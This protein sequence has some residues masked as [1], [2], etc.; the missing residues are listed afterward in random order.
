MCWHSIISIHWK[1]IY[2]TILILIIISLYS[3]SAVYCE[4]IYLPDQYSTIQSAINAAQNGDTILIADGTYTGDGN[5]DIDY[6]GKS[7]VLKSVN[8]PELTILDAG[9]SDLDRHRVFNFHLNEDTSSVLDGFT[10]TGGYAPLKTGTNSLY[11]GGGISCLNSSPFIK[12]CIIQDNIGPALSDSY[13]S[14][15]GG[16]Y[17]DESN[18]IIYN[19][20]IENNTALLGGG[21]YIYSQDSIAEVH[22][23]IFRE[24]SDHGVQ[25]TY[26]D[27]NGCIFEENLE[28]GAIST[29]ALF[30]NC[31]FIGNGSGAYQN[32]G[33]ASFTN[34]TFDSNLTYGFSSSGSPY[35]S[36]SVSILTDCVFCFNGHSGIVGDFANI[37][38]YS[39]GIFKNMSLGMELNFSSITIENVTI[40]YNMMGGI[41]GNV[42]VIANNC[43]IAFNQVGPAM[44]CSMGGALAECCNVFGNEGGDYVECLL[45]QEG[46]NN[47]F[48]ADPLFCDVATGDVGLLEGSP[49]L[50]EASPCESLVGAYGFGCS[51]SFPIAKFINYGPEVEDSI[52]DDANPE[53]FWSYFDTA[54][55]TQVMYQIQVGTDDDWTSVEMWDSGPVSSSDTSAVYDGQAL[56]DHSLHH[57]RIRVHNGG[58]WGDW[59]RSLFIPRLITTFHIPLHFENIQSGVD[60]ALPG[61]T[62]L[63]AS[64][65]YSGDGN[66]DID[67]GGTNLVLKSEEGPG[68]TIIECG[69]T[70]EERHRGFYFHND[71]DLSSVIDGFTIRGGYVFGQCGGGIF[72]DQASPTIKNC[73]FVG[74]TA[75]SGAALSIFVNSVEVSN[76]TF[77]NN[78]VLSTSE[79]EYGCISVEVWGHV[80]M[81][82]SIIAF[83]N[84]AAISSGMEGTAYLHCCDIFS[85]DLGDW[86]DIIEDQYGIRS[87]FSADP[88]FCD[89]SAGNYNVDVNSPCVMTKYECGSVVGAMEIACEI[90][91][92]CGDANNDKTVNVSDAVWIVNYVFLGGSPPQPMEAGEANCDGDVNIS[93]AVW[94]INYVFLGGNTPCDLDSD[95]I[96][97]C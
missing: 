77:V 75:F 63:V 80:N 35:G 58:G 49:C 45:G 34:C 95:E 82:S 61:D 36:A 72:C 59:R 26:V 52:V 27:F 6:L 54:T 79:I 5:R 38:I 97:D 20:T 87:N 1:K 93:D 10:I 46:V 62:I 69:G 30:T 8:G 18:A 28:E 41:S 37:T 86:I 81:E 68:E 21:L 71:E 92:F 96:S 3:S 15:G 43:I 88:L 39:S 64:G 23:C 56:N 50:P 24:N 84:A 74:N 65:A 25:S 85:N 42:G 4:T 19:C 44:D 51:T 14:M 16:I 47:N 7:I 48:Y 67:F 11:T 55:T 13:T 91:Y 94:I 83:N 78:T 33:E 32:G 17:C 40:A 70:P 12:N 9:A 22:N 60:F 89:A 76:C 31:S 73:V 57:I 90:E 29:N 53:L 2:P 66:R